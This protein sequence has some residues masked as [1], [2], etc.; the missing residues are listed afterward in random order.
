[1]T[2]AAYLN[3]RSAFDVG[4]LDTSFD[5]APR[6][7]DTILATALGFVKA[8]DIRPLIQRHATNLTRFGEVCTEVAKTSA[9]GG[10]PGKAYYLN[11][12]QALY[13]CTKSETDNAT[14][15]TIQMVEV[16]DAYTAGHLVVTDKP[17]HVREHDRRTST[18]VDDALRLKK[19]IDRLESVVTSIQPQVQPNFCAMIVDGEPVFVDV[20]KYDGTGRAVVI[21]H[22]GQLRIEHVEPDTIGVRPFGPRTA[23]GERRPGAHGTMVRNSLMVV[24]MVVDPLERRRQ[25]VVDDVSSR[26]RGQITTLLESG[27]WNDRQIASQLCCNPK[28]VREVRREQSRKPTDQL[29]RVGL[30]RRTIE[31]DPGAVRYGEWIVPLIEKGY[32]NKMISKMLGCHEETVRR[33]R[34]RL[35]S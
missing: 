21:G 29:P 20:N 1:M 10:R 30:A 5:G 15:V 25:A 12:K 31:H 22:N 11:K 13:I 27:P 9:R 16:F 7:K 3:S 6:M 8:L 14:E 33:H 19:N 24:G 32:S 17:V 34:V 4:D 35:V 2:R 23:L 26:L 18:K 28:L